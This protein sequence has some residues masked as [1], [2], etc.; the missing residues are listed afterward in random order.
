MNG[1]TPSR[2]R[3]A[4]VMATY[5][6]GL[7]VEEQLRSIAG[8]TRSP[9]CLVI[10]D[11]GSTDGTLAIVRRMVPQMPCP[12]SIIEG[13]QRLGP[14]GNF[15]RA[16]TDVDAD[17]VFLSDQDDVWE[18]EKIAT[19]MH[20]FQDDPQVGGI[21]TNGTILSGDPELRKRSLWDSVGFTARLQRR[22]QGDPLGVLLR[23]NVVT[24]ASVAFR[25]DLLPVLLPFPKSGWHDL[26]IAVLIAS[27]SRFEPCP[28]PLI[29]YRLHGANAAGV[30]TGSRRSR[31][32]DRDGHLANLTR[33]Q[34][35]WGD[36]R[37]RLVAYG[38]PERTLVRID[39]KLLHLARRAALPDRRL[40][41]VRPAVRELLRGGYDTYAAGSWSL[42]RDVVGP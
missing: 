28:E 41:R 36:L 18:P 20:R 33:Q 42:V 16:L 19:V 15:E 32:V 37:D 22:W 12:V 23:R 2:L 27:V 29:T 11:D 10:A 38:A 6:G 30:P 4:V 13:G 24:G 14:I 9:D 34:R 40:S 25:A 3:S 1:R 17:I 5:N 21:F 35:H 39:A 26:S 7:Y 8:Q 31:V